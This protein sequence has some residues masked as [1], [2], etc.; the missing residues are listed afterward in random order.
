MNTSIFSL[1]KNIFYLIREKVDILMKTF[2]EQLFNLTLSQ[3]TKFG[4]LQIERVCRQQFSI[5]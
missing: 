1:S 2:A 5:T 4:L 3:T